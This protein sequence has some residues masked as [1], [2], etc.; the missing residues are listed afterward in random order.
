MSEEYKYIKK[1][2]V[3]SGVRVRI[4]NDIHH[5]REK[6]WTSRPPEQLVG[7]IGT[8]I[9]THEREYEAIY[10]ELLERNESIYIHRK[11]LIEVKETKAPEAQLFD[12][13]NLM[14]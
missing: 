11:D 4:T 10:I 3:K 12:T 7:K 8:I 1:E 14:I 5:T 13:S 2:E 9:K 6:N